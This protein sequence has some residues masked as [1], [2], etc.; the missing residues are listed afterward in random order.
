MSFEIVAH[1]HDVLHRAMLRRMLAAREVQVDVVHREL[2]YRLE[3]CFEGLV[4]MMPVIPD[5]HLKGFDLDLK[6]LVLDPKGLDTN[7][8]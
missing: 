8:N 6:G 1:H 7:S 3:R 5:D 2:S 4:G